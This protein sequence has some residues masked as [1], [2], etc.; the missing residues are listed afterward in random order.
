M[1]HVGA[2]PREVVS[3][4]RPRT[5]ALGTAR[6]YVLCRKLLKATAAPHLEGGENEKKRDLGFSLFCLFLF[7]FPFAIARKKLSDPTIRGR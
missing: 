4:N 3:D 7:P 1:W 5:W 2:A 6:S